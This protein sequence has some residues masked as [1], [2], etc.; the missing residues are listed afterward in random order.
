MAFDICLPS[1][2]ETNELNDNFN[3]KYYVSVGNIF[4]APTN[5]VQYFCAT[6]RSSYAQ[7]LC[8]VKTLVLFAAEYE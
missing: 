1:T 4:G 5:Q 7:R 8:F 2:N 6:W 3:N